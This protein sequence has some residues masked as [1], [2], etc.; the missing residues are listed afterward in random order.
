MERKQQLEKSLAATIVNGNFCNERSVF[1]T[2]IR[3]WYLWALQLIPSWRHWL[4]LG[5]R[6]EGMTKYTWAPGMPFLP[7]LGGGA[8]LPQVFCEPFDALPPTRPLFTDDVIFAPEKK[9]LFQILVLLDR[10]RDISGAVEVLADVKAEFEGELSVDEATYIISQR[11]R[12]VEA[13]VAKKFA[14]EGAYRVVFAEE[15]DASACPERPEPVG[16]DGGRLR[17]EVKARFVI[18]RPDRFIFAA[19]NTG[20]DLV[21]ASRSLVEMLSGV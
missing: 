15:Y 13:D 3:N 20:K 1:K 11:L 21:K 5:Q 19:C 8:T 16:Y 7:A 6:Q 17:K 10:A 12:D 2:F 18:V 14:T 9:V 4:E